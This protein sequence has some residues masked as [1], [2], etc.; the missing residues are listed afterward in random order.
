MTTKGAKETLLTT[1]Y[2]LIKQYVKMSLHTVK[3]DSCPTS[4]KW[5]DACRV[6]LT[7]S[8]FMLQQKYCIKE[9]LYK[10][11]IYHT[12]QAIKVLLFYLFDS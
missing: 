7:K 10:R 8:Q 2:P 6:A 3:G 11:K 12:F 5:I 9:L 4:L 1:N